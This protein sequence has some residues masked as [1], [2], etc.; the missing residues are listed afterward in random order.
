[1][2]FIRF[3]VAVMLTLGLS[4][5]SSKVSI[6]SGPPVTSIEVLKSERKMNLISDGKVL[7]TYKVALG[8]M[9]EGPK[10]FEA[11]GKTPEGAYYIT[12]RNPK[13]R[14]YLSLGI[15]YPNEEDI[16]YA[17]AQGK[18]PGG[19]IFIHGRSGYKGINKGDWTAGCIAV[20][21]KEMYQIYS[22]V[23]LKTPIYIK[24]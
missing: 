10:Q 18:R 6:Y 1:M 3:L 22:M 24:P 16:A 7:K 23:R 2:T 20:K 17:D 5:C 19:E 15:S 21:D 8:F 4:A 11:D 9:P 14:Y 13:S 12:H